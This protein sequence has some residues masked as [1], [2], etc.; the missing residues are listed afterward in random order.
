[1]ERSWG[2]QSRQKQR[3]LRPTKT[4]KHR[5]REEAKECKEVFFGASG[6]LNFL[7]PPVTLFLCVSKVS[8]THGTEPHSRTL[9]IQSLGQRAHTGGGRP[10]GCGKVFAAHGQQLFFRPRHSG[11]HPEWGMYLAGALARTLS[12]CLA[13]RL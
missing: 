4:L 5:G 2:R 6:V 8:K 11:P 12:Y 9:Q 1:M 3:L 13:E 10:A 7:S